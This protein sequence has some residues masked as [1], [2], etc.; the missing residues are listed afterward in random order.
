MNVEGTQYFSSNEI[1]CKKCLIKGN[2]KKYN[3]HQV[4]QGAIV[5]DGLI[6][7]ATLIAQ[8]SSNFTLVVSC[9]T[10]LY[11]PSSLPCFPSV[12]PKVTIG[13][14]KAIPVMPEEICAQDGE[15]IEERAIDPPF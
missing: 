3:C 4:L 1:G 2:K 14:R 10:S 12:Q 8:S 15:L 9:R 13:I 7:N 11:A 6:P 5:K